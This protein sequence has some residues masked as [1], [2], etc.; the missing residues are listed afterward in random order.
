MKM[1]GVLL[2][3]ATFQTI[4]TH[5]ILLRKALGFDIATVLLAAR[6]P[7]DLSAINFQIPNLQSGSGNRGRGNFESILIRTIGG[8]PFDSVTQGGG[9][10][11]VEV[12]RD[13]RIE[14]GLRAEGE[15][16]T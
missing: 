5:L 6:N 4:A 11:V 1:L 8:N 15:V 13:V 16:P 12:E 3:N 7:R 9:G 2:M 10:F 14:E